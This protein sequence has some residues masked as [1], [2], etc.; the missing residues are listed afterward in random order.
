MRI[1]LVHLCLVAVVY[2]LPSVVQAQE[3]PFA[4]EIAAARQDLRLAKLE[5]RDYWLVEYPRIQ[6]HLDAQIRITEAEV[7]TIKERI[8]MYR[9]FDRFSTGSAVSWALQDLRMCLL[10]GELRLRDLRAERSNLVRFRTPEWRILEARVHDT[11]WRVAEL[12]NA[13]EAAD[14]PGG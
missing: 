5:F 6:R 9:P 12:E 8:R 13:R 7:R 3:E 11:R 4:S 1:S 14:F 2:S 10:D